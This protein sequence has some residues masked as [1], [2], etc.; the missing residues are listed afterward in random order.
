MLG[1]VGGGAPSMSLH[2]WDGVRAAFHDLED[3]S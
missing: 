1:R 2:A 3:D